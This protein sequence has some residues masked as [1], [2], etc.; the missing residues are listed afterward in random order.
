[1]PQIANVSLRDVEWSAAP[2]DKGSG[3]MIIGSDA[4]LATYPIA[5]GQMGVP[6]HASHLLLQFERDP[7]NPWNRY[8]AIRIEQL[9]ESGQSLCRTHDIVGHRSAGGPA[10]LLLSLDP[11]ARRI[12]LR[13]QT[14]FGREPLVIR[15]LDCSFLASTVELPRGA[16]G[17]VVS[18]PNQVATCVRELADHYDHY[19]RT[20]RALAAK[21]SQ[22]H[23]ADQAFD[24]LTR[25]G[26]NDQVC[27]AA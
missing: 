25:P 16:V 8:L 27:R 20:A 9:D 7:P 1:V 4:P 2:A 18:D 5:I 22:W 10:A 23:N 13:L 3:G 19:D 11:G 21:W 15:G 17:L 6:N 12:R 24:A 26:R 14:A